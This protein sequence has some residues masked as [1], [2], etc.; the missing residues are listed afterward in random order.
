MSTNPETIEIAVAS[1]N[2]VK[3]IATRI[4]LFQV[5]PE[6]EFDIKGISAK[7]E[8]PDQ[9]IGEEETLKGAINRVKNLRELAP[10]VEYW[11]GIEGGLKENE[12]G[13]MEAFAYVVIKRRADKKIG[14]G[15]TA[16]FFLPVK[17]IALIKQ[18][19]E[20]GD[21]DDAI[22]GDTNSKQKDG[23]VGRLTHGVVTR[24][25]YYVQ[26]VVMALIPFANPEL[27]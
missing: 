6:K 5:F 21:A 12:A 3:I 24:T 26:A 18:G 10:D 22:F 25:D 2:P 1:T 23:T 8:V 16:S 14:K 17:M 9:P 4:G 13:G 20:L 11:V 19:M 7:S 15:R 27:Y